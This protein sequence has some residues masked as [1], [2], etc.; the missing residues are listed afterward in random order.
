MLRDKTVYYGMLKCG[1]LIGFYTNRKKYPE[2]LQ[3]KIEYILSV[4]GNK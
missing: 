2:V 1:I 3:I 4:Y